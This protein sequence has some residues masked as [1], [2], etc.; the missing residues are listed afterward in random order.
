MSRTDIQREFDV[1]I[2]AERAA[3]AFMRTV[4]PQLALPA[5]LRG[6]L[7]AGQQAA[8]AAFEEAERRLARARRAILP[9]DVRLSASA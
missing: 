7:S 3:Y 8:V 5:E 9:V 6:P 1:A 4:V 2:V